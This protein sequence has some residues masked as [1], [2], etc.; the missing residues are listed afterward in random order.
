[1]TRP[2][3]HAIHP[4]KSLALLSFTT[5]V[6]LAL[7]LLPKVRGKVV[8]TSGTW[9]YNVTGQHWANIGFYEQWALFTLIW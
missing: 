7:L 9:R 3:L 4:V 6:H 1:M 5:E 8:N 2:V